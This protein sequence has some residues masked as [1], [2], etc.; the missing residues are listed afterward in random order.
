METL[1]S[2]KLEDTWF[3]LYCDD[4]VPSPTN[5]IYKSSV[6]SSKFDILVEPKPP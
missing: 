4:V 3:I 1:A 6:I 2:F 5:L